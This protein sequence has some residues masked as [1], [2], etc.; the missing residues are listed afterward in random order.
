M[1]KNSTGPD[2][3]P[4]SLY[5][6]RKRRRA[7]RMA[8]RIV[9]ATAVY[10]QTFRDKVQ[11]ALDNDQSLL[12]ALLKEAD[13]IDKRREEFGKQYDAAVKNA[14]ER[15]QEVDD[16]AS[17]IEALL[18]N[19]KTG[20]QVRYALRAV[21]IELS[22]E[23]GVSVDEATVAGNFYKAAAAAD[24]SEVIG[25]AIRPLSFERCLRHIDAL[26]NKPDY[27]TAREIGNY[28]DNP[29][30]LRIDELTDPFPNDESVPTRTKHRTRPGK[31]R[32]KTQD[33]GGGGV[34]AD[35]ELERLRQKLMR[36][37]LLPENEAV[38]FKLESEIY[39]LEREADDEWPDEIGG[40]Q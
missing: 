35:P 1:K 22:N 17:Q 24:P 25:N 16:K 21:L 13:A 20:K 30:H 2:P 12:P 8:E 7:E 32:R 34:N 9:L 38:A 3:K 37:E 4:E 19:P 31:S 6:I 29:G 18:A 10:D 5:A 40:A 28:W 27:N 26:L 15:M 39:K 14:L 33:E 23:S 11:D 36:L